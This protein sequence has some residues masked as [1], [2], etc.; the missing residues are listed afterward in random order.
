MLSVKFGDCATSAG[1]IGPG[2][3]TCYSGR[4]CYALIVRRDSP[5]SG[6]AVVI[7]ILALNQVRPS[8]QVPLITVAFCLQQVNIVSDLPGR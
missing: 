8:P 1:F 5:E 7:I 3:S 2:S 6:F 4:V